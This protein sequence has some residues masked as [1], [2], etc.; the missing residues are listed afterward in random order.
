MASLRSSNRL[1]WARAE[2]RGFTLV[3]LMAVVLI[4]ALLGALATYGVRKY[5][6]AA[7]TAEATQM[8]GGI[9]TAQEEYKSEMHSYLDVSGEKK[10]NGYGKFYPAR[11]PLKRAKAAWGGATG[12]D[13]DVAARWEQLGVKA[14]HPVYYIYGCAA[15]GVGDEVA[16]PGMSIK[17]FPTGTQGQPWYIAQAVGDLDGDGTVGLW[18]ISSFSP[19]ISHTKSEE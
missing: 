5:L 12:V 9:A 11:A 19:H 1:A 15:G 4:V 7:K 16:D 10:L 3:E 14:T 13:P 8:L 17:G 6:L 2:Q 18:V